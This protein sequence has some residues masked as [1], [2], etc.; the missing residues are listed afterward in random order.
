MTAPFIAHR[1]VEDIA[2]DLIEATAILRYAR[3]EADRVAAA[4]D[5]RW[6]ANRAALADD[7]AAKITESGILP[8]QKFL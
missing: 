8:A 1:T 3:T 5:A 4:L 2:I 6:A 7:A